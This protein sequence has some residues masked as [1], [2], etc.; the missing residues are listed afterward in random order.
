MTSAQ[1]EHFAAAEAH[2]HELNERQRGVL[3]LLVQGKTN[4]EI[5]ATLGITLDGAKWNVSE[6]LGKLG[7][8]TREEAADYWRWRN[9]HG[10]GALRALRGLAA[11]AALKW[12][13]GGVAA[14]AVA[15]I[16]VG[17]LAASDDKPAAPG[18][19]YL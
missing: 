12:A 6:I 16:A 19:F 13:A 18:E 14:V 17:F 11:P 10:R 1:V 15:A 5:A 4:G 8:A 9:R 3:D 7:L 2:E